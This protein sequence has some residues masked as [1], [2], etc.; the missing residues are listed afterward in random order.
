MERFLPRIWVFV[1]AFCL[2]ISVTAIWRIYKLP[3]YSPPET[4]EFVTESHGR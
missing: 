4:S 3:A 2:G 1:V